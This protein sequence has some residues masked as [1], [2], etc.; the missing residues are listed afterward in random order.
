MAKKITHETAL[1]GL[2]A[3]I[4]K[5]KELN[6][7]STLSVVDE[8][9]HLIASIRV[10]DAAF[11]TIEIAQNKAYTAAAFRQPTAAWMDVVQPGAALYGLERSCSRPFVVFGGGFPVFDGD[12]VIG[13]VGVSGGP[14]EADEAIANVIVSAIQEK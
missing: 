7:R 10:D 13:G 9:G 14:V 12:S 8:G 4:R 6:Q 3:G 2:T 5:A 1:L 11:G